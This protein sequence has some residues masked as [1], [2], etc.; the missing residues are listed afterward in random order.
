MVAWA[1]QQNSLVSGMD[2]GIRTSCCTATK[3][4][5]EQRCS[6][7]PQAAFDRGLIVLSLPAAK[8]GAVVGKD[9]SEMNIAPSHGSP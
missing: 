2:A 1:G 9:Q 6:R 4:P 5:L 8:V 7:L 3:R